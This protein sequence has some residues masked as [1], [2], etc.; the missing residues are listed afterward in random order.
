MDI[1]DARSGDADGIRQVAR[2]SFAASYEAVLDEAAIEGIVDA[3]FGEESLGASLDDP[4]TTVVVAEDD[5][6]AGFAL[7]TLL[8]G[9][10]IV[11]DVRWLHVDPAAR[12]D[13]VGVSL[14]GTLVDRFADNEAAVVRGHV[15]EGN[16]TGRS[17]YE[18]YGFESGEILDVEIGDATYQETVYE[19]RLAE[20]GEGIVE[21]V[22]GPDG[23]DLFVNYAGGDEGTESPF[24]PVFTTRDR[25]ERYGWRC[26]NCR[27]LDTTMDSA[28]RV[29][30]SECDNVRAATRWDGAY[31]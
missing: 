12:G 27:S 24:Y 7:G 28:G 4:D 16:E 8:E 20:E 30:C 31:L 19:H 9:D 18:R 1:R 23:T 3:E 14:L 5:G 25:T 11:G 29:A 6:V 15:V 26:G 2:E 13:D 21:P 10:P 17:F 22:T